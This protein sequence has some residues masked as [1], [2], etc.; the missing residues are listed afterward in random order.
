MA[1]SGGFG[2]PNTDRGGAGAGAGLGLTTGKTMYGNTAYGPAG[3][4]AAGYATQNSNGSL[5]GFRSLNGAPMSGMYGR[6]TGPAQAPNRDAPGRKPKSTPAARTMPGGWNPV[7]N[8]GDMFGQRLGSAFG[9]FSGLL[10]FGRDGQG[11]Y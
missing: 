9:R 7:S 6:V 1:F 5:G 8:F 3:G 2:S 4:M 10:G 11:I